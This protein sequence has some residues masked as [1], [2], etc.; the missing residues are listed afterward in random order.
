MITSWGNWSSITKAKLSNIMIISGKPLEEKKNNKE[1]KSP[2][3]ISSYF[4]K[5]LRDFF[6]SPIELSQQI[7]H[8]TK[9]DQ[10]KR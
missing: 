7:M 6:E 2:T 9:G 5:I 4:S 10:H 3:Y 8:T 1:I